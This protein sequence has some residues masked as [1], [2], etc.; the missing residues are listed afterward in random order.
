MKLEDILKKRGWADADIAALAPMLA[1][2]RFRASMEEEYGAVATERD[3]L[4]Q[5]DEA[6]QRQLDEQWQPRV[7]AEERKAQDATRRIS[8]LETELKIAREYGYLS[9]E[10]EAKAKAEIDAVKNTGG[11]NPKDYVSMKDAER[12]MEAEGRAIAMVSDLNNEYTHLTGGKTLYE[13]ETE[14]DGRTIRG[15]SALREEAKAKRMNLDRYVAEKFDFQGKRTA[16]TQKRQ[17]EHDDAIRKEAGDKARQ[18]LAE[19]YGNPLMRTAVPSRFASF[20]P[21]PV[22]GKQPW[23]APGGKPQLRAERLERAMKAQMSG[24][25]N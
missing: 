23:E 20:V 8:E 15:V 7:A 12:L 11:F 4:K 1:D 21:K 14:I 13:Y 10:A 24:N 17:Q 2:Q 25:P 3:S 22:N 18:E 6:W 5:K 19:Q 9:P 16:L